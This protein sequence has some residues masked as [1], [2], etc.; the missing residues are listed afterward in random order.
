[1][2]FYKKETEKIELVARP[3]V[4]VTLVTLNVIEELS[5]PRGGDGGVDVTRI[6]EPLSDFLDTLLGPL[7]GEIWKQAPRHIR[8]DIL[9][10]STIIIR[11]PVYNDCQTHSAKGSLG[12]IGID[13]TPS[14]FSCS[15]ETFADARLAFITLFQQIF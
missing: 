4:L 3:D 11:S 8:S 2:I 5:E 7:G 13:M 12:F 1:M 10:S 9:S 6:L 14:L 15:A